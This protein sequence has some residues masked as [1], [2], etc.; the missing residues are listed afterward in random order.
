MKTCK[1]CKRLVSDSAMSCPNCGADLRNWIARI[2]IGFRVLIVIV[3]AIIII[4]D[5]HNNTTDETSNKKNEQTQT[6]APA[7]QNVLLNIHEIILTANKNYS[8]A[9]NDIQ[10]SDAY[11][12]AMNRIQNTMSQYGGKFENWIGKLIM[13]K[14]EK[15][16]G[17]NLCIEILSSHNST[18]IK[19]ETPSSF[20]DDSGIKMN[21]PVYDMVR[22]LKEGDYVNFSGTFLIDKEN[23]F[24]DESITESGGMRLPEFNIKFTGISKNEGV[25]GY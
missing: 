23:N 25:I 7:G 17:Q 14:T 20:F 4:R 12:E 22:N 15:K 11:R 13:I 6:V 10:R 1:E 3:I 16:G 21:D 8:N 9:Q 18:S 19:F 24:S 2:P 5:C